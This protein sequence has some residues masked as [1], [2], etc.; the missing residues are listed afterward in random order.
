MTR[1][2]FSDRGDEPTRDLRRDAY[3]RAPAA[4]ARAGGPPPYPGPH[5]G[6]VGAPPPWPGPAQP[7]PRKRR[8]GLIAL[9]VLLVIALLAGAGWYFFLGP[10]AATTNGDTPAAAPAAPDAPAAAQG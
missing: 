2:P 1:P 6:P 5:P 9:A 4:P 8:T 10:G 3:V 7:A